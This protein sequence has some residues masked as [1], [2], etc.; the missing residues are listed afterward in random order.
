[1]V[2]RTRRVF[3]KFIL[4]RKLCLAARRVTD[5]DYRRLQNQLASN[6]DIGDVMPGSGDFARRVFSAWTLLLSPYCVATE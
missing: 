6:L 5:E 4:R 1:M 3:A 2:C